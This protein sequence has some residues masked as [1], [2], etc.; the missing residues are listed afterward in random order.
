M[1]DYGERYSGAGKQ[2]NPTLVA[3]YAYALYREHLQTTGSE[4][5]AETKRKLLI[6][7]NW[8][9]ENAMAQDGFVTWEYHFD[10]PTFQATAPWR[11]AMAQGMGISALLEAYALTGDSRFFRTAKKALDSFLVE[12]TDGGVCT[13][14]SDN[15]AVYEEV[16]DEDAPSS[17]ILN[18]HIYALAGVYDYWQLTGD[19]EAKDIFD[20]GVRAL[21]ILLPQYDARVVSFY[22]I[23]PH[24]IAG[25]G[26][27]Y[28]IFHVDQLLWLHQVTGLPLFLEY[29]LRFYSYEHFVPFVA[30]A[31]G[32]TD[33]GRRGADKL[34]LTERPYWSHSQFPTW[35]QL[36]L[37]TL[38]TISSVAFVALN[39]VAAPRDYNLS[40]SGDGIEW[41]LAM[42]VRGNED[43]VVDH[44]LHFT[45]GRFLRFDIYSDNGNNN[46]ALA[47]LAVS[48]AESLKWPVAVAGGEES[49]DPKSN[50]PARLVDGNVAMA[51]EGGPDV[52]WIVVDG[53]TVIP[54]REVFIDCPDLAP[55]EL[56]MYASDDL[57]DWELLGQAEWEEGIGFRW[58]FGETAGRY[59]KIV[60]PEAH[61]GIEIYEIFLVQQ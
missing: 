29:A 44:D 51:W 5:R 46:V 6:Q 1:W 13:S 41:T 23:G 24:R 35:V 33:P 40:L 49:R 36:D 25:L 4:I 19:A 2:Y 52:E 7:A 32:A 56:T 14:I 11:S 21:E 48:T 47:G 30:S 61:N 45:G 8:F 22:D 42:E 57:Y 58:E 54:L 20:D 59:A 53:R 38:Q 43:Q 9:V 27:N 34:Y 16:A 37:G 12:T 39:D 60:F 31:K 28:N 55:C 50:P 26:G 10:Q 15:A 3:R 18:G 17:K